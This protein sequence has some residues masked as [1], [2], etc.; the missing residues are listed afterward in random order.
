MN[1]IV[2]KVEGIY[3][4]TVENQFSSQTNEAA[5]SFEGI[6]GDR[7]LGLTYHA[8]TNHP[9]FKGK[10][11]VKNTRQI[12]MM[13]VEELALIA[14]ELGVSEIKA[15]W[16]YT[17]ILVS[18]IPHLSQIPAGARF[19]FSGGLILFNEGENFPCNTAATIVQQQYPQI[20]GIQQRFIKAAFHKRGLL[21]WVEHPEKLKIDSDF[22]VALPPVWENLW[23]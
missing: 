9:E 2:G 15:E 16:I 12:S 8:K 11:E 4:S 6:L 22:E 5:F 3:I 23:N 14:D 13:S 21:A 18:G 10:I 19:F 20:E 17:N 7:H 1:K